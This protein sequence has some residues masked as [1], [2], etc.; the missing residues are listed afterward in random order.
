M[1]RTGGFRSQA[2]RDRYAEVYQAAMRQGPL[3]DKE[4]DVDTAFGTT[5]VYRYGDGA[6]PIVL[7]SGMANSA[8]AL[9]GLAG[10]LAE[11]HPVYTVDTM[12]EAGMSAQT[13][14][15][16]D[17]ADRARWLDEV[18]ARLDLTGVHLV[19][20]SSG[21]FYAAHQAIHAPARLASVTLVEPTAVTTRFATRIV[22]LGLL[23]TVLDRDPMWRR[24]MRASI[25]ADVLERPDV[26]VVIAGIRH[27]R[28]A[29]PPQLRVPAHAIASITVPVLA[30]FGARSAVHDA[31]RGAERFRELVPHARVEL[32]P[33][34]GHYPWLAE[35]DRVRLVEA[36]LA[37]T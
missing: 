37:R 15:L 3:P 8:A 22:L 25:G 7:L 12:G 20:F 31:G 2:D 6:K 30:I 11:H 36:I 10:D 14:P 16:R 21:G 9:A 19:G 26:R 27:F 18:M 13:A 17:H 23:A 35:A 1:R 4:L 32:W 34:L 5:R 24:F 33:R 29:I 28:S